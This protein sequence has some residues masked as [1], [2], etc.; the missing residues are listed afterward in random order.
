MSSSS[1][2]LAHEFHYVSH[3]ASHLR[4]LVCQLQFGSWTRT[5]SSQAPMAEARA[6]VRSRS[7]SSAGSRWGPFPAIRSNPRANTDPGLTS[8]SST[9]P[10]ALQISVPRLDQRQLATFELQGSL[11]EIPR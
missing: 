7:S 9:Y 10:S 8:G 4:S 2:I 1:L 3:G 6:A 5:Q 11:Q